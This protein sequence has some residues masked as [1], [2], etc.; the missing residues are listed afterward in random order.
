M[1]DLK[2][3]APKSL[4]DRIKEKLR[5]GLSMQNRQNTNPNKLLQ[6]AMPLSRGIGAPA[7]R[8]R[9]NS[10]VQIGYHWE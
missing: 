3:L 9:W 2:V 8:K 4:Q 5:D 1:P 6:R 7:G 10:P